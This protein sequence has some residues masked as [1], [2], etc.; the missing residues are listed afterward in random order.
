MRL[1]LASSFEIIDLKLNAS[2][3]ISKIKTKNPYFMKFLKIRISLND[4]SENQKKISALVKQLSVDHPKNWELKILLA[5]MY[6]SDK[7]YIESINLYSKII[8]DVLAENKWSIF[9]S[10]GIAYERIDNWKKAEA[11]LKMAMKLQ[12]NDPYVINY[13]AYSWLDRNINIEMALDLL[14]KA[15]ELEPS[16]GYILDSLGW[17]YYLSNSIEQSIYFL[18]KAVSFLPNDPTL[19]DHLGDAYWKSGRYEEAQ[20]QWKRVLIIDPEFKTKDVVKK[21]IEFGI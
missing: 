12:P 1:L 8:D 11:D 20:S 19:N 7:K 14:E 4:K 13:L 2:E 16:D 6:R 5:D 10:R 17:A 9:Y 21:K 3:I 18:E 15:V